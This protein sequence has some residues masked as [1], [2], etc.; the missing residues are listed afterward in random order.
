M[1]ELIVEPLIFVL[2]VVQIRV[3]AIVEDVLALRFQPAWIRAKCVGL[4]VKCL[5]N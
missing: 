2:V 5:R 3:G 4:S 1:S